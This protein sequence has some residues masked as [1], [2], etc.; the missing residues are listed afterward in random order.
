MNI[1]INSCKNKVES[2]LKTCQLSINALLVIK[3]DKSFYWNFHKILLFVFNIK[4]CLSVSSTKWFSKK[5]H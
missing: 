4:Y 3:F 2:R 1:A 5:I